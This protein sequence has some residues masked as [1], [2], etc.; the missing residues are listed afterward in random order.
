[1]QLRDLSLGVGI[2]NQQSLGVVLQVLEEPTGRA[3]EGM[4]Q[5]RGRSRVLKKGKNLVFA[6]SMEGFHK[7]ITAREKE[8]LGFEV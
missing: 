1:M 8:S 7:R 5:Q 2:R 6:F 4:R 3:E